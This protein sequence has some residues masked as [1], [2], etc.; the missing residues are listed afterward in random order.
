MADLA[1]IDYIIFVI[2][3]F[4]PGRSRIFFKLLDFAGNCRNI[5]R[6]ISGLTYQRHLMTGLLRTYTLIDS[7]ILNGLKI[8]I[9]M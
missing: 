3:R 1:R 4:N 5:E 6:I 9:S 2:V 8:L 7:N